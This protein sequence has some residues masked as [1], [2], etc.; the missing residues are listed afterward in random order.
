V[1]KKIKEIERAERVIILL[2]PVGFLGVHYRIR[3]TLGLSRVSGFSPAPVLWLS[4]S[5]TASLS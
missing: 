1:T 2:A 3:L 5:L 4:H